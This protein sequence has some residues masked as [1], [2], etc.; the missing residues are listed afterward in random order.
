[1]L[2]GNFAAKIDDK[3]RLKI[4]NAF[5]ALIEGTARNGA[6]R[7]EPDGGVRPHVPDAGLAGARRKARRACPPRIPPASSF[8]TASTTTARQREID[9]QGRVVIHPRLRESAGMTG[10]VDVLGQ[11]R[12]PRR[13]EPRTVHREAAARA[14]YRRRRA[15]AGGVR[16]LTTM[17]DRARAGHGDRNGRRCSRRRA[18]GCSSIARS[19]SAATAARCS[20]PGADAADRARSRSRRARAS[21]RERWRRSAIAS[22]SCTPTTASSAR[23]LDARGIDAVDGA[24]ADLGVSSMQLDGDG[25]RVQLPARRAARHAD[26]SLA[27]PDGRRPARRRRRGGRSPT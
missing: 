18:A 12:L 7:D 10:E 8:S 22:S 6:V 16:D 24:L 23:V 19:G 20:T 21:P 13:V 1:M 11:E 27:G 17:S 4:P 26:G 3:G 2:R 9:I 14:V 25:P 5:R 15:G